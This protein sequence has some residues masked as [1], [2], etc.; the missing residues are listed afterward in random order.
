MTAKSDKERTPFSCVI[1][2]T[3]LLVKLCVGTDSL[4]VLH[5]VLNSRC[6]EQEDEED[7]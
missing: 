6:K 1:A 7:G 3:T 2:G 4:S 5:V